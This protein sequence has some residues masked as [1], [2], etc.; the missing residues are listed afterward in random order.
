VRNLVESRRFPLSLYAADYELQGCEECDAEGSS[1][2]CWWSLS[3]VY[4]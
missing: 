4:S 2:E 3:F 1:F